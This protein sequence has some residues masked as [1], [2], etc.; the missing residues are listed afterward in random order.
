MLF[1]EHMYLDTTITYY[2]YIYKGPQMDPL[3]FR[4]S[5]AGDDNIGKPTS[6]ACA[7]TMCNCDYGDV[8]TPLLE[9]LHAVDGDW[10]VPQH[11]P[12]RHY[13]KPVLL[14]SVA[15]FFNENR[16]DFDFFYI[17]YLSN[18]GNTRFKRTS[19]LGSSHHLPPTHVG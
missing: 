6:C 8:I 15:L 14:K 12:H 5:F 13:W 4:F 11:I 9:A 19:T 10:S 16:G 1:W 18:L 2:Y 3:F 7:G 17:I